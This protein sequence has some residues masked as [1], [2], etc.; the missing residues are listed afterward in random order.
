MKAKEY[1]RKYMLCPDM[2]SEAD[3]AAMFIKEMLDTIVVRNATTNRACLGVVKEYNTKWDAFM[4]LTG[5]RNTYQFVVETFLPKFCE[6]L[7]LGPGVYEE[8]GWNK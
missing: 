4:R 8:L 6:E 5:V 3:I 7:R 1:A 2:Q